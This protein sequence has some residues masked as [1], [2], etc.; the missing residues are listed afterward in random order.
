MIHTD[1]IQVSSSHTDC[2][3]PVTNESGQVAVEFILTFVFGL[4]FAFLFINQAL[5]TTTGFIV[6]YATYMGSRVY[7]TSDIGSNTVENGLNGAKTE[8]RQYFD[9]NFKKPLIT[10][11]LDRPTLQINHPQQDA[12][13]L[14]SGAYTIFEQDFSKFGGFAPG[15]KLNMLSE[16]F[17]GKEPMQIICLQR[18][19]HA[20]LGNENACIGAA[21]NLDITLYDNGC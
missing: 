3:T 5:N 2:L 16:S 17:L 21:G 10:L 8:A 4:G 1:K 12:P 15:V 19:C 14:F 20:M 11:G 13:Y 18:I 9:S 7:L 6:H